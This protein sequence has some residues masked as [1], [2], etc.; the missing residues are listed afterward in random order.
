MAP[1][2]SDVARQAGVSPGAASEIV[3]GGKEHKYN[4][5]TGGTMEQRPY[6]IPIDTCIYKIKKGC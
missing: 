3:N 4:A 2:I 5:G 6:D 1:T